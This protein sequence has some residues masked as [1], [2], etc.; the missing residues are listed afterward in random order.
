MKSTLQRKLI[1]GFAG[2]ASIAMIWGCSESENVK[3]SEPFFKVGERVSTKTPLSGPIKGTLSADSTY[4]VS[5][6]VIIN[7]NDTLVIQP[8][9]QIHF[10]GTATYSFVVK[11]SL[12]SL[13]TKE[14]PIYFTVPTAVKTDTYGADPTQ[15]PA[16]KGLW[17]GI[18]GETTFKSII[19]KWTHLEFG[20][21]KLGTSPVSFLANGANSYTLTTA[22]PNGIFVL[23]DSWVYG[24]VDDPFRPFGGR[25][26]VMRN[27]FEK[28]GF[29][30]G[31]AMNIKSGSVGNFAYNLVIGAATNGPKASNNGGKNPQTNFNFYNNTIVAS[32]Y[33]RAATGRGGSI[34]FEEG[35]RGSFYNNLMV[36]CKYG[37]RIVAATANYSGNALVVADTAHLAYGYN[38]NYVDKVEIANEIY[39]TGFG[40]KPQVTDIP[41]P[42]SFLPDG[43]KPGKVYDG[44]A[45]VG[46]NNP[47][48]VNF[49][50]PQTTAK[51]GDVSFVGTF[52]FHLKT[53][54]PAVS[55]GYTGFEPLKVVP[56]DPN[57]GSSE[58]TPPGKDIGAFQTDGT[59]NKH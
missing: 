54:S 48:F 51:L 35:S 3:V 53:G 40:T 7:E 4:T 43:Y 45:A 8:G 52:D 29:T 56:V 59:G 5:G 24:A 2:L 44:S 13:G 50:L 27:T 18:L 49:P 46:K 15:D 26:N 14:K 30:G 55:K 39:P 58:I 33:R 34:N 37:P 16:Y 10:P 12:L 9:A 21:G 36:N 20:G 22:N 1:S 25:F 31:E 57:F 47:Q 6:D 41:L 42:S 23:E 11:G 17:G 32:G 19:I 38:Y 28:S